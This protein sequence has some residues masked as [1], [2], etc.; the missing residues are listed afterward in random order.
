MINRGQ[1]LA[2]YKEH[3]N[4]G[5]ARML[6]LS[7]SPMEVSAAGNY[8]VDEQGR[9]L[10]DCGG[11]CVFLLG[12]GQ[13]RIV[14][15][16][17]DQ[18][19][20]R[21]LATRSMI[22]PVLAT[23]STAVA[24]VAPIGLEFVIL[25]TSGTEAV[26]AA[27]KV[28]KLNG[29]VRVV[30]MEG[31]YHGKTAGALSVTGRDRVRVPFEPL[32]PGVQRVAYG[33]AAA[34]A[35][36]VGRDKRRAAVIVE[37][38]QSEAGVL[39]PPDGYLADVRSLCDEAGAILILDEISTGLGRTG[40]MWRC[41]NEAIT[42][43]ILC[44]GKPL[45]G[46]IVPVSAMVASRELFEPL[47]RE[48]LLHGST[49]GGNPLAARAAIETLQVIHEVDAPRK[50]QE[51]GGG[52]LERLRAIAGEMSGGLVREVR[53]AG[54]LFGIEFSHEHLAAELLVEMFERNVIL[55]HSM[56]SH[57]VVRL[58]PPVTISEDDLGHL[59]RALSE[60]MVAITERYPDLVQGQAAV[61]P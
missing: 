11:Y 20:H 18:L 39:I 10:L 17:V 40:Q 61:A 9:E 24:A 38:I 46:G 7:S 41:D 14:D 45:G 51:L 25:T 2:G 53:G 34:L 31:A 50:A 58:T 59:Y 23:A 5:M 52:I 49:F 15:A 43:D 19:R 26:E 21:A 32:L 4:S 16:V 60:S 13:P 22:D 1:A 47:N 29:C 8:V 37:P 33:D 54:L 56:F 12:H 57:S 6:A 30:A 36:A 3:V 48:P 35:E 27:L 44:M 28:A 55:C 42:P